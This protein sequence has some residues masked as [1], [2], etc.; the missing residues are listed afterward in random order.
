MKRFIMSFVIIGFVLIGCSQDSTKQEVYSDSWNGDPIIVIENGDNDD[1]ETVNELTNAEKIEELIKTLK[2]AP[3]KDNVDVD[4]RAEDYSFEWNSFKH[5]VWVNKNDR[6]LELS[7]E[8][9]SSYVALSK[10][11][12][13]I[14]FEILTG[15]KFE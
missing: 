12:S 1:Q 11:A 10:N 8:G 13:K 14:V 9:R 15:E 5:L 7:I 4:I 2:S 3:W 6:R